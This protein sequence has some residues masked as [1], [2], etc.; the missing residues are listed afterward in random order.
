MKFAVR[1]GLIATVIVR[2]IGELE[3]HII[4][5][6]VGQISPDPRRQG[7][8]CTTRLPLT[9]IV[10]APSVVPVVLIMDALHA[11]LTDSVVFLHMTITSD[12]LLM[13]TIALMR[14]SIAGMD[15]QR[16]T[17][18]GAVIIITAVSGGEITIAAPHPHL[19]GAMTVVAGGSDSKK[20]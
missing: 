15:Q 4:V 14:N 12:N 5:M 9:K 10:T 6:T 7:T 11:A 13:M 8:P 2:T 1:N 18:F 20:F 16:M 19:H 3:A 17:A